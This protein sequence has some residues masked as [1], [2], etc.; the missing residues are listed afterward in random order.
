MKL[1]PDDP[2]HGTSNGYGTHG[3]RCDT[4]K[5][6][7]RERN[8][9]R[10][11]AALAVD[12]SRHGTRNGYGHGCRCDRCRDAE[13][14]YANQRYAQS[15]PLRLRAVLRTRLRKAL[16]AS[17]NRRVDRA[18]SLTGCTTEYLKTYLE[19]HFTE[20]MTWSNYGQWHID[21]IRPCASF[22]LSDPEQQRQCFHYTN[23]Q[24]LW[25]VENWS[26]ADSFAPTRS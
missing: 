20:G 11:L 25:A 17:A 23:L 18:I 1:T 26:K 8:K 21:H 12:D 24:P 10:S 7:V 19:S 13:R 4:C 16:K 5:N 6:Y 15:L 22:D 14:I 3:C 9:A 2:R